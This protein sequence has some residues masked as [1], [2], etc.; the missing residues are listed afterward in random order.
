[1]REL[2]PFLSVGGFGLGAKGG[3]WWKEVGE[4]TPSHRRELV[5]DMC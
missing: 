3:R 4:E 1:M 5:L 2:G